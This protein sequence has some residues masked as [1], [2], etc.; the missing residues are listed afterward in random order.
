M[1]LRAGAPGQHAAGG[2]GLGLVHREIV[3]AFDLH[4]PIH[5]PA[6]VQGRQPF[7]QVLGDLLVP[8]HTGAGQG[9]VEQVVGEGAP[10]VAAGGAEAA[11]VRFAAGDDVFDVRLA[12]AGEVGG[13][14]H[15]SERF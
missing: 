4:D 9:E 10:G 1:H 12:D 2:V 15:L 5:V 6:L 13:S 7:G 8:V 14:K 3:L 11:V